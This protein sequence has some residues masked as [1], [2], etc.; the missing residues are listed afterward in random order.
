MRGNKDPRAL[1]GEASRPKCGV[2]PCVSLLQRVPWA[3]LAG[4]RLLPGLTQRWGPSMW[5]DKG[6]AQAEA[7][8]RCRG[9]RPVTNN[10]QLA[11]QEMP[12]TQWGGVM[13][14]GQP[15][16]PREA[17][18]PHHNASGYQLTVRS[19]AKRCLALMAEGALSSWPSRRGAPK[20]M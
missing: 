15:T 20:P 11:P 18:C 12:E 16:V 3:R 9:S 13:G 5:R 17:A 4:C 1:Q 8:R 7:E 2:G 6:S 19:T 10:V 14:A